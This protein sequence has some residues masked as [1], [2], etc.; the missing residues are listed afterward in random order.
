MF[1]AM[2]LVIAIVTRAEALQ[3]SDFFPL[4]SGDFW[5][6]QGD[7]GS[8]TRTV[9][10]GTVTIDGQATKVFQDDNGFINYFSNDSAGIRLHRQFEEDAEIG[11]GFPVDLR[12]TFS[13]PIVFANATMF[14]GQTVFSNGTATTNKLPKVGV[15]TF[16]YSASF[17][18]QGFENVTV[19]AGSFEALKLEG[20]VNIGGDI[21]FETVYL[22]KN[23]GAV[24]FIDAGAGIT[25]TAELVATN[26]TAPSISVSSTAVDFG[27]VPVRETSQRLKR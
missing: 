26:V 22:V 2:L 9:L 5:T 15:V 20:S 8:F 1:L 21:V 6:Y 13:P 19:P 12:V 25:A 3:I 4:Q 23:I 11:L 16:G 17:T 18:L 10:P 27:D 7:G 14:V 24:K